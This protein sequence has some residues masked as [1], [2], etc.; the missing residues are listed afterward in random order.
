M[1]RTSIAWTDF[2][3]NPIGYHS[4]E[5]GAST[6]ACIK[7]SEGCQ[8]CYAESLA[9]RYRKGGP[10]TVGQMAKAEPVWDEREAHRMLT[11]KD[12][13]GKRVF[14]G[15]MTDIF[16][17]WV[18]DEMLDRLFF[19]M[20]LRPN[21]N[22]QLLTKRPARMRAY[23]ADAD[24]MYV[25]RSTIEDAAGSPVPWPLPNVWL[26]VS[27]ENQARADERIPE[28]LATPAAIRFVS[29]EPLLGAIDLSTLPPHPHNQSLD[30]MIVGGESGPG[31]RPCDVAWIREI[32]G[33]CRDAGV[34]VFVKQDSGPRPGEWGRIPDDLRVRQFPDLRRCS[35]LHPRVPVGEGMGG[36]HFFAPIILGARYGQ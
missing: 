1:N 28:L 25:L 31:A 11:A 27:A 5:T 15:D 35:D 7:A 29:A 34:P 3:S 18:P 12:I 22:F 24:R 33:Q 23:L 14:V 21:V 4:R 2:T 9:K 13:A 6:W 26:G 8:N 17:P 30:W 20:A 32:V 16:G 36:S 19:T 10:F